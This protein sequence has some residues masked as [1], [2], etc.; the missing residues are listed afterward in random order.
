M[1]S[2]SPGGSC[3][4]IGTLPSDAAAASWLSVI[5]AAACSS[6][7]ITP[8]AARSHRHRSWGMLAAAA[9]CAAAESDPLG[10]RDMDQPPGRIT[11]GEHREIAE[12]IE[13]PGE[14]GAVIHAPES[15]AAAGGC[16]RAVSAAVGPSLRRE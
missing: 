11:K 7:D 14:S 5:P 1:K 2:L 12:P 10:S 15:S 8:S 16:R 6:V 4:Q 13:K 3:G 9:L